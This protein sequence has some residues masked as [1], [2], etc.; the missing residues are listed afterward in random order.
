MHSRVSKLLI[1]IGICVGAASALQF[2]APKGEA[3]FGF[4][5][6]SLSPRSAALG[7]A[8]SALVDGIVDADLNPAAAIRDSGG[9]AA[10]QAYLNAT[11][12]RGDFASW[13]IPVENYRVTVQIRYLGYD[14]LSGFDGL[15]RSTAGY[16]AHSLKL[17]LG[18]AGSLFG[19]NYGVSTSFAQNN[20]ADATY[21]A[22]LLNMGLQRQLPKGFSAGL[23]LMN[24][25]YWT[26]KAQDGSAIIAPTILQG[27][28]SY[29]RSLPASILMSVA[30]DAR[31]R[32]D[33]DIAFPMGVEACWQNILSVR[34]GYPIAQQEA[35]P[36]FGVGLNWSRYG[37]EYAYQGNA[38]TSTTQM[39]AL[40][41]RY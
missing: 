8:G 40:E 3:S 33:E 38:V 17:Q 13:N 34:V 16:G 15:D 20:I 10:G 25:D 5:K 1:F 36:T 22:G 24:A 26:S 37:F 31:K 39:W 29:S 12:G 19:F 30:L 18:T 32:N 2:D 35:S 41:I 28:L 14:N 21:G 4:L 27:G 23:S 7:G 11:S 6:L 9:I